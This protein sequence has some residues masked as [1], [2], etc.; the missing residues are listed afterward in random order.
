MTPN[1]SRLFALLLERSMVDQC[2]C[3]RETL[4]RYSHR[5]H[6]YR[7]FQFCNTLEFRAESLSISS[8]LRLSLHEGHN[9]ANE[10]LIRTQMHLPIDH[11][12]DVPPS[13]G[14]ET[15]HFLF[16]VPSRCAVQ[17]CIVYTNHHCVTPNSSICQRQIHP[18]SCFRQS[19]ITSTVSSQR[20]LSSVPVTLRPHFNYS[21]LSISPI[22]LT[23]YISCARH[24]QPQLE[25][26]ARPPRSDCSLIYPS[27]LYTHKPTTCAYVSY[28]WA[29]E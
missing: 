14:H 15:K 27:W 17:Y 12:T 1:L 22:S 24:S 23:P 8:R 11:I 26:A 3:L 5:V 13:S 2:R 18:S 4:H 20:L 6:D 29:Q 16:Y 25:S 28:I 19:H 21:T 9:P 7:D 10:C